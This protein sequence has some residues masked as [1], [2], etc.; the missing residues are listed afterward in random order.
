MRRFTLRLAILACAVLTLGACAD[1][2]TQ[3]G[4]QRE[5]DLAV[6]ALDDQMTPQ[7]C[8]LEGLCI[9]DPVSPA[10]CDP[11]EQL[12]WSCDD[13]G[14][15]CMT[16]V[17]DVTG[18]AEEMTVQSCPGAGDAPGGGGTTLP[19]PGEDPDDPICPASDTGEET[20]EGCG[21]VSTIC[22]Q[23]FFGNTQPALITVGGRNHEFQFHSSH[24]YPFTRLTGGRS[25][26]T[27]KIGL[28]TTSKDSWWIAEAGNITVWCR[29]A[30]IT[31]T[32]WVGTVT[33]LDSDLHMVIGPGHP[34]F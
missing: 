4:Q 20:G 31:R 13:D 30:W 9:L 25:P 11:Y 34:D 8:V 22:P 6:P 28:P 16:S 15:D 10:P 32:L 26:A 17:G 33:V 18:P 24:A 29:G 27:Y 12:D 5:A 3:S 14:G 23:P 1:H 21:E 2:P 7:G 19:A